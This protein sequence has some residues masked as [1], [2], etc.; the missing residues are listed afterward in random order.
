MNE[1]ILPDTTDVNFDAQQ[2]AAID[3]AGGH[4]LVVAA[5]G[6]GKTAILA[7]RIVRARQ[8]GVE[9]GDML[10]L[11][12]TNR[13]SREMRNRITQRLSEE[14]E[15]LFVGNIHHFCSSILQK[16]RWF[17]A[18]TGVIDE[19][20]QGDIMTAIDDSYTMGRDGMIVRARIKKIS[21][22]ACTLLQQQLNHP[23]AL[24]M[25]MA[26]TEQERRLAEEYL[27]YK[28]AHM[29][30][31]FSDLLVYGYDLIRQGGSKKYRWIQVDEVQ[32]LNPL[33]HAIIDAV[34]AEEQPTV[35][36][37]GDEQQSI[38][39]FL[40]ARQEELNQLRARCQG[41][42]LTLGC[43]YRSPKYLLDVFNAYAS[44]VL[45]IPHDM[46]PQANMDL[47]HSRR[48]LIIAHSPSVEAEMDRVIRMVHYYKEFPN[49]KLAIL[50][51]TNREADRVSLLLERAGVSH[52]KISGNDLF[53][54]LDYKTFSSLFSVL[55]NEF[56]TLAWTRLIYGVRGLP[57]LVDARM[58]T[59]RLK[60][61]MI[62]PLDLFL[63]EPRIVTFCRIF[64]DKEL[65]IF[66]TE[67]T[68]LN[69][70]EDDIVQIAA[71][72]V[73]QGKKVE[74]SD[75]NIII[76]TDRPIP[77]QVGGGVNPLMKEYAEREH[78]SHEEG[79]RQF[80]AYVDGL[81]VLGHNARYDYSIL[82]ENTK[83]YLNEEVELEVH[84]SLLLAR[85]VHPDLKEYKLKSL[86]EELHLEGENSHLANDDIEA[87]LSLVRHCVEEAEPMLEDIL[88]LV[89]MP[90]YKTLARRLHDLD[91][92][93]EVIQIALDMPLSETPH[94]LADLMR[95][96]YNTMVEM[97]LI[98]NMGVKFDIFLRYVQQ[99]WQERE[100]PLTLRD[101]VSRHIHDMTSSLNE[102]DLLNSIR[103]ECQPIFV[104]TVHKGKGLEFDN[105][106]VMGAC[107]GTYPSFRDSRTLSNPL[108]T[109]EAQKAARQS[110]RES[111]R[112][113]YVAITRARK[114]L[115][116]SYPEINAHG[117]DSPISHF[118]K[119]IQDYFL[120]G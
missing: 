72:K 46:L 27:R 5:P 22:L 105:V 33:Q 50:V 41:H 61:H 69:V 28:Q 115:C 102:G 63:P 35:M 26:S 106:V 13:A 109:A 45:H 37:L 25:Q 31:D 89:R 30:M 116:I 96:V 94:R 73:R 113:L 48:D 51:P 79:L 8:R 74:C 114:R 67:T 42:I 88:A 84:D 36:Y 108:S 24:R 23:E 21:D 101:L 82:R 103:G 15:E 93:I 117:F 32:D 43:N 75:F 44:Q 110:V 120:Q 78:L 4:Y 52:F 34:T 47:P 2:Q 7:E 66:D 49:E 29:M 64:K 76:H 10:C 62:T 16:S 83:R 12:F 97:G 54:N 119:P 90:R 70:F 1:M 9:L 85:C 71:F 98:G 55:V 17:S 11:T 19:E 3:A 87:T 111:A 14:C 81:P 77:E 95:S 58:L 100:Q 38:Y 56:N 91:G 112:V 99:E 65:V 57:R 40:G 68:G 60:Q 39:A 104:M 118:L 86:L 59:E 20:D 80:L 92:L 6:C 53:K 18:S 107:E